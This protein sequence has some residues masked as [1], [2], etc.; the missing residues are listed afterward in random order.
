MKHL[1]FFL[2]ISFSQISFS[3]ELSINLSIVV[4]NNLLE[5][6]DSNSTVINF[7]NNEKKIINQSILNHL[8]KENRFYQG[9]LF[10]QYNFNNEKGI[11]SINGIY[12]II[13][14]KNN[15][16][17]G[18]D[19]VLFQLQVPKL[20]ANGEKVYDQDGDEV[21]IS[22]GFYKSFQKSF[23]KIESKEIWHYNNKILNKQLNSG[24]INV[25]TESDVRFQY[26][27]N[28][29]FATKTDNSEFKIFKK[30]VVYKHF[31]YPTYYNT[32]L[33]NDSIIKLIYSDKIAL[34]FKASEEQSPF[35]IKNFVKILLEDVYSNQLKLKK[36]DTNVNILSKTFNA[37][38]I[39]GLFNYNKIPKFDQDGEL[40]YDDDGEEIYTSSKLAILAEDIL[41]IEFHE[42]WYLA[43]NSFQLKKEVKGIVLLIGD[44]DDTGVL[45]GIKKIP[46]YISFED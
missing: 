23:Y 42:D 12:T 31:F 22:K 35:E 11:D 21:Y 25:K 30:N 40:L 4:N 34:G 44:Y 28:Y 27:H 37:N 6:H 18:N 3:Q 16:I 20:D 43:E 39:Y 8:E 14:N 9:D 13:I 2:L 32:F 17:F 29:Y 5:K 10:H 26:N 36:I 15:G 7:S 38:D 1:L 24:G 19:S 41:G 33:N 45:I 46:A